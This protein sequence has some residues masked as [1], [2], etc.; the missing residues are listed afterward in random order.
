VLSDPV[1]CTPDGIVNG[2]TICVTP[3]IA[4][5]DIAVCDPDGTGTAKLQIIDD[6][7]LFRVI[8]VDGCT[9][10]PPGTPRWR[11]LN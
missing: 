1:N 6:D 2:A 5:G 7:C 9:T 11:R 3:C 4:P 10:C 8:P